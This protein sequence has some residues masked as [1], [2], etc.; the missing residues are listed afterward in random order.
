MTELSG[1]RVFE[2]GDKS[3]L[4]DPGSERYMRGTI[5]N[6]TVAVEIRS[7]IVDNGLGD[8]AELIYSGSFGNASVGERILSTGTER[9]QERYDRLIRH[10][11]SLRGM[12]RPVNDDELF[13]ADPK[14]ITGFSVRGTGDDD[15]LISIATAVAVA[16]P[17]RGSAG[18][19]SYVAVYSPEALRFRS[20]PEGDTYRFN[21]SVDPRDSLKALYTF[22]GLFEEP[23]ENED[24]GR[25][26]IS[27]RKD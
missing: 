1:S 21:R 10:I 24:L 23:D 6:M 15:P 11:A 8:P 3:Q 9:T 17:L 16:L 2:L 22:T 14:Q 26:R 27:R 4:E 25:V 7:S 20:V 13:H 18:K 12:G 5:P 19:T